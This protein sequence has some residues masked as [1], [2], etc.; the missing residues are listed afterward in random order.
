MTLGAITP[1]TQGAAG[2]SLWR[3][4]LRQALTRTGLT[5]DP[6]LIRMLSTAAADMVAISTPGRPGS[7]YSS[8]RALVQRTLGTLNGLG[9]GRND[10]GRHR[11]AAAHRAG[12]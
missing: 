3:P 11:Q 2:N 5:V 1:T 8:L 10:R 9:I 7:G 4:V 6:S 12:C